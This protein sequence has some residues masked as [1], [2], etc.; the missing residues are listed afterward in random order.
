MSP[1]ISEDF[2]LGVGNSHCDTTTI[3]AAQLEFLDLHGAHFFSLSLVLIL[4]RKYK[5]LW[6]SNCH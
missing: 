2:P 4:R 3:S 6:S 5:Y 1:V